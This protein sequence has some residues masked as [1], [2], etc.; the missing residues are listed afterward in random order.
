[1][2]SLPGKSPVDEINTKYLRIETNQRIVIKYDKRN[3]K[4]IKARYNVYAFFSRL[5][6]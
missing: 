6:P 3:I 1:M 4:D 5:D 2:K